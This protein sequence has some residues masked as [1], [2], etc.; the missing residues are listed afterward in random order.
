MYVDKKTL[1]L[2]NIR[3]T[4]IIPFHNQDSILHVN[5]F[6]QLIYSLFPRKI[7]VIL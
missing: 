3:Y 4:L 1:V 6:Y 5:T 7:C 2:G